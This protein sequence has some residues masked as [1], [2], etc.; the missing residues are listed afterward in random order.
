MS[1]THSLTQS[2]TDIQI[3]PDATSFN[4]TAEFIF[5]TSSSDWVVMWLITA[6]PLGPFKVYHVNSPNY[7]SSFVVG[8][9]QGTPV[10]M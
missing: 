2:P 5:Y 6:L 7:F 8:A 1:R 3:D 10:G 4:P 9:T